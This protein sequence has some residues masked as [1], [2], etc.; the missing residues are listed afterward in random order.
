MLGTIIDA[1]ERNRRELAFQ[2]A[3]GM[4][5]MATRGYSAPETGEACTRARTLAELLGE[6]ALLL[7]AL[8]GLWTY[9]AVGGSI[10]D[11]RRMADRFLAVAEEHHDDGAI[12]VGT[13][14]LG[15]SL[16]ALG[17]LDA[18]QSAFER[19]LDLYDPDRHRPLAYS[20]GQ[21]QRIAARA[22]LSVVLWVRGF[23]DQA[24]AL[25]EQAIAEANE[26]DH[27]NSFGYALGYGACATFSLCRDW[28]KAEALAATL[29]AHSEEHAAAL[30]HAFGI[31]Y[32]GWANFAAGR[33][34]DATAGLTDGI[35]RFRAVRSGLRF[36]LHLGHLAYSL[37]SVN[38]PTQAAE[39]IREAIALSDSGGERWVMPELVR[40][41]ATLRIATYYDGGIPA[42]E[43]RLREA[44]AI[45]RDQDARGWELRGSDR[46]RKS[47][48][49]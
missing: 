33:Y 17:L 1:G 18:A 6:P 45:A 42:A 24:R 4:P 35:E 2:I 48:V 41:D 27:A 12:L 49:E 32:K 22:F 20:F 8:Y 9:T 16:Q 19:V 29:I 44:L 38:A 43:Q 3:L 34:E 28:S 39:T 23:P 25:A 46:P 40:I 47:A 31:A 36:P 37:G 15:V 30:W 26:L 7:R 14:I 11:S 10:R 13:R 5:L 21:D